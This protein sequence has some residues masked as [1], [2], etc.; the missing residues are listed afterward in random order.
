MAGTSRKHPLANCEECPLREANKYVP[1][2][3][4]TK[5]SIAVVG[6]SPS[7]KDLGT[8][9]PFTGPAG[10][11][12]TAVLRHHGINPSD[13]F[14]TNAT[15]CRPSDG[16]TPPAAAVHACRPRLVAELA[17]RGVE[18]LVLLGNTA[19]ES[20][21]GKTGITQLRVGPPKEDPRYPGVRIVPTLNPAAALRQADNFLHLVTDVG[22]LVAEP[23]FWKPPTYVVASTVEEAIVM[24]DEIDR[25]LTT[26]EDL[27]DNPDRGIVVDI[28]VDIEKDTSYD[29]PNHYGML[30]VG[31]GYDVGKVLVLSE[32]VMADETVRARL[33]SL[34]NDHKIVAQNGKF[35]LAGLFP[36]V[37]ALEL[38]FDTMLA[39][40]VF[41]ERPGIHGLK[42]M[43]VEYL[44]APQ[45]D[46]EIKQYV[47]PGIG[48]GAIPRGLLYKYNAYDVSCTY[49]MWRMWEAKFGD[50]AYE[51]LRRV[52]DHLVQASN[53]LMFMELNGIAVDR[54]V[55]NELHQEFMGTLA[56]L[57]KDIDGIV[58]RDYDKKGGINPRS[59]K[60]VKEYLADKGIKVA[61][62]N[63][64]TLK[65]IQ[66]RP[67]LPMDEEEVRAFVSKLL[68][69]RNQAK[70]HGTYVKGIA[71]RMYRGRVYPTFSL[72]GTTTG[73]LASRNPNA[74][75]IPRDSNIRRMFVPAQPD[76][77]F[78]QI[79]Y[80]QA[81]LRVLSYL[82][83]DVYFRDIF[84]AGERDVFDDLTPILYPGLKKADVGAAAWKEYR[85]RVK[86]FVYGLGYGR[87]AGS[88]ASEYK[89]TMAEAN[90]LKRNFFNVI[91]E[92]VTF[93]A[94]TIQ[95]VMDGEDLITPWG[96]RRRF[97]L[98][99]K[100]NMHSV[101]NEALAFLPQSTASDICLQA[102]YWTRPQIRG[103]GFI[104]NIVH[105]SLLIEAPP[106]HMEEMIDISRRNMIESARTI[107]GDYVKFD[108]DYKVGKNWGEV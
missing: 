19:T 108:V 64:D 103:K 2:K 41:D 31:L 35:D 38:Y 44:G 99:T 56:I 39:S 85:I 100:E 21:L 90:R 40:Y 29:H 46:L 105:D 75:N 65:L 73:R 106:Q 67:R 91:P 69:H 8:R 1:S 53:Q 10:S 63:E 72:H 28:E 83:G 11:L 37:G 78:L 33:A 5:A 79:D 34:L 58:G 17:D 89:L 55:L 61:S 71:K 96:R 60:Q 92:I 101:K 76:N 88:I 47:G 30:C 82:A 23:R 77:L 42:Y 27:V 26:G 52:H 43:A 68:D 48:Y 62:T 49:E 36:V 6:E 94:A 16:A 45:Y 14:L 15:L 57:E 12:L 22:K 4:P 80:S 18:S 51:G 32:E 25:R 20:V 95:K 104:R 13:V 54:D 102:M 24:M 93:Q 59:P 107:V 50:P 86:A 84:N 98:I 9:V 66:E 3:G 74:Q 87:E 7:V 97:P 81:E 70:Q